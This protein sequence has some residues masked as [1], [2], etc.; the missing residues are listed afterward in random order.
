M[1]VVDASSSHTQQ[2]AAGSLEAGDDERIFDCKCGA[3]FVVV[4]DMATACANCGHVVNSAKRIADAITLSQDDFHSRGS[5]D[6]GNTTGPDSNPSSGKLAGITLGHFQLENMLGSGGMG[7]VYKALDTSLQRYVAVKVINDVRYGADQ[8]SVTSSIIREAVAQAR[9]NHPNVVTIYYVG[10]TESEPFLAMEL[11]DGTTLRQQLNNGP[12][13][14]AD[15]IRIA[16]Q[17]ASALDH[18]SR[19]NIVHGDIKPNNLLID[20]AGNVKLSDFGLARSTLDNLPKAPL[21]GTPAYMAPELLDTS[22]VSIQ[23][24]MYAIGITLF[25]MIFGR[26][27]FTFKGQNVRDQLLCHATKP[28]EY[29]EVW[30]RELPIELKSVLDR[31]LAKNPLDRYRNYTELLDDLQSIEPVSTT[32]AG[33][34]LRAAAFAIDETIL[35]VAFLPFAIPIYL[36][37]LQLPPYGP[38]F[39]AIRPWNIVLALSALSVPLTFLTLARLGKQSVGRYLF[40]LRVTEQHGLVL[41]RDQA[42]LRA[43]LRNATA[44]LLPLGLFGG[45]YFSL[46]VEITYVLILVILL[47]EVIAAISSK[48]RRSLHDL[49]C[50]S[51]VVLNF[52]T[53]ERTLR[54]SPLTL[55]AKAEKRTARDETMTQSS[56]QSVDYR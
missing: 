42:V 12:I 50:H 54:K 9:L 2:F 52:K 40:Q 4:G 22:E 44:W 43:V 48:D 38:Y 56:P 34:A 5:F 11:V 32:V 31:L 13:A 16:R 21:S 1:P 23:S 55:R 45:I 18:A 19:I 20:D 27:P 36:S 28:V 39:S 14:Y 47:A 35:L 26:L 37:T 7:A 10:R 51:R 24:D 25:E 49:L 3:K 17:L 29:P 6:H 46:I 41:G 15:A 8:H 30:P 33:I 53:S